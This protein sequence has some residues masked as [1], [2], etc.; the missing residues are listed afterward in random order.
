MNSAAMEKFIWGGAGAAV[1]LLAAFLLG[2]VY[3]VTPPS[4]PVDAAYKI[5]R[6]TGKV[7][8]IKTYAKPMAQGQVRVL[9]ARE[10]EVEKTRAL[11]EE[12]AQEFASNQIPALATSARRR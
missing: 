12:E 1:L 5:N 11:S 9:V 3:T 7:W 2:G 8:L 10:A 4:G 6:F